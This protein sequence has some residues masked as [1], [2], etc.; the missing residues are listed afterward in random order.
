MFFVITVKAQDKT[1]TQLKAEVERTIKK[2]PD[3]TDK[4][5]KKGG[6]FNLNVSQ[7]SLS[8]WAAGGDNFSLSLNA[9]ISA[10]AFYKKG[11]HSWDNTLDFNFGY[12]RTTSLGSRKNDDRFDLLSKYGYAIAP[13]WNI[14]T[15]FNFRT[16]LANGYTYPGNV[17]TFSSAFLS[18]AYALL[19]IGFDFRPTTNFSVFMSPLSARLIIVKNNELA[20]KGLYGVDSGR[21]SKVEFGAFMSAAYMKDLNKLVSYKGRLDLFSNYLRNPQKVDVY[22]SNLLS[23]KLSKVLALTW[24]VDLIYD[25]DV[26]IFG[27]DGKSPAWQFKSLVGLGLLVKFS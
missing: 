9:I 7:T 18:P 4:L 10:Y 6:L 20:A 23:V 15:L 8:N 24:N 22:M 25:D 11:K 14:A 27:K 21:H 16:Q 13:K 5:W 17:K 3:T 26:R 2:E 1:V 19:S 12:L